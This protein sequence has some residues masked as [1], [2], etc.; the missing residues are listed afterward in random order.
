M[1]QRGTL[2]ERFWR[3]VRMTPYCWEWTASKRKNGYGQI[4]ARAGESLTAHRVSWELHFGPIPAGL[5]VMHRCDNRLCVNP[6][7]LSLGSYL[8][9]NRDMIAKGRF[10]PRGKSPLSAEQR[11]EI[12]ARSLEGESQRRISRRF[13]ITHTQIG[14]II[15]AQR[16]HSGGSR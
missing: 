10:R 9:N 5:C 2:R 1:A 7:H 4:T 14:K 8:D 11:Q 15:R 3:Y 12:V 13:G 16:A 6:A